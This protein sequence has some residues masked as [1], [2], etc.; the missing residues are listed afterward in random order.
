M[1]L[2]TPAM[3][4]RLTALV[5][6]LIILAAFRWLSGSST[7][8]SPIG[9]RT[10]PGGEAPF[11]NRVDNGNDNDAAWPNPHYLKQ[12]DREARLDAYANDPSGTVIQAGLLDRQ[13]LLDERARLQDAGDVAGV[14][15]LNAVLSTEAFQ[16]A[17]QVTIRWLDHRDG[18]TGLFPHTLRPKDRYFSY[19]DVGADLYPFLA[20]ATRYLVYDR[21]AEILDALAQERALS[22]GF[23]QDRLLDTLDVRQR[24]PHDQM[25][26]DVEYAKDGLLP[27]VEL[28]GPDPWLGRM[29]EV[30]NAVIT[31]SSV[32]TPR[33]PIPS[34][35][36]EVN[37][38]ML[39]VLARRSWLQDD[40]RSIEMGRRIVAAY[41]DDTLPVTGDIPPERWDFVAQAA[42]GDPILHLGDHGDEIVS[43][44]I[45]WERVEAR[46]GL[47]EQAAHRAAINRMLVRLLNVGRSP[48][49][50][51]YDGVRYPTG[52]VQDRTLNDNWG[53]LG[54]AY[55]DQA[56][57][58][59][60]TSSNDGAVADRFE[61]SARDML[62]ATSGV[63]YH[64]WEHG[65][66]DGYAD[67]LE[68]ALYLLRY[69]DDPGAS[70][71]VDQ[72]TAV[73]Y[74]FQRDNGA[75]TDENID[76][77]Y[78]RTTMLYGRWL[79]RGTRVEPWSPTVSLGA[80]ADGT[81]LQVH[82]HAAD[83]WS[84]R[85][86]FDGPRHQ[87]Y[88]GLDVDYPRL[89]QWQ[90]WWTAEPGRQYALTQPGGP[91]LRLDGSQLASGIVVAVSPGQEYQLRACPV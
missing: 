35:A 23:P 72:Q 54:Q 19:G 68:S 42:V 21:Y 26:A 22:P 1:Q 51:W 43:G 53:Y 27:L 74:G 75:V 6:V 71:W 49:G 52:R 85:L 44:L 7:L 12:A 33:G 17:A 60:A 86:L 57:V 70:A 45:E 59:R 55:L 36:A 18:P 58:L 73:L 90:E 80:A 48:G 38:S 81:C 84:G 50:L 31:A 14:A 4:L 82:L 20:I 16:R 25:L 63:R 41:L 67:T 5:G 34:D 76:G 15:R 89:N 8:T 28:L 62:T 39:Q 30:V 10:L 78:I 77:N 13:S 69:V 61:Q 40:P 11:A 47:P 32:P 2:P 24:E 87:Q 91:D 65:D 66:M 46:L 3:G 37:G 29:D 56:N 83:A 88:L 79:T 9:D 64:K